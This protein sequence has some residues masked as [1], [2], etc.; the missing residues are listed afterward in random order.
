MQNVGI[1]DRRVDTIK[2]ELEVKVLEA[3]AQSQNYQH[4]RFRLQPAKLKDKGMPCHSVG[5][6]VL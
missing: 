1:N 6:W 4:F 3:T 2:L 5:N